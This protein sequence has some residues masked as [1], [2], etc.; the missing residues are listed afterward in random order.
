MASGLCCNLCPNSYPTKTSQ[1]SYASLWYHLK[2]KHAIEHLV[3]SDTS[4]TP[5]AKRTKVQSSMERKS[6]SMVY[7][8]LTSVYRLSFRFVHYI[9]TTP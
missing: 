2:T 1:S 9:A 4:Q 6:H 3:S 8:D 5:P 7:A